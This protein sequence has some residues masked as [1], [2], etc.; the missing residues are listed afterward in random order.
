MNWYNFSDCVSENNEIRNTHVNIGTGID[1]TI[2]DLAIML[3]E[4][5]GFKGN[6]VFNSSKPDG[7]MRKV[8]NVAKINDWAGKQRFLGR[9]NKANV[10]LVCN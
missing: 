10:S 8:T 6:F 4:Q 3:K 7:T 1:I 9:R 5:I 2:A